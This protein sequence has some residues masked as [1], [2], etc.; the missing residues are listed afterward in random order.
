MYVAS[1]WGRFIFHF[2]GLREN[3]KQDKVDLGN[4]DST[5]DLKTLSALYDEIEPYVNSLNQWVSF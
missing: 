1:L 3:Q 5:E 2:L 4:D